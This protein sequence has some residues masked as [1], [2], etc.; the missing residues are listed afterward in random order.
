MQI[1]RILWEPHMARGRG[2]WVV[3][4][5]TN[6]TAWTSAELPGRKAGHRSADQAKAATSYRDL[7]RLGYTQLR[8]KTEE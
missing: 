7:E 3:L 6:G 2:G 5:L 4:H 8:D 1:V